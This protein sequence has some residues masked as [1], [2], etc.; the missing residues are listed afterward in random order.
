MMSEERVYKYPVKIRSIDEHLAGKQLKKLA[1]A[2]CADEIEQFAICSS[3]KFRMSQCREALE[4]MNK[5]L[6][7]A[8]NPRK[9]AEL[10]EQQ[11]EKR[12]ARRN[13]KIKA[14]TQSNREN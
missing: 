7:E 14:A 11:V 8:S 4:R 9:Y 10:L 6:Q 2:Q 13:D 1:E 5:C 3:K 12:E